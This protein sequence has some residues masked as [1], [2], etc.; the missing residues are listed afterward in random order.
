MSLEQGKCSPR[1]HQ[2]LSYSQATGAGH[3][4]SVPHSGSQQQS[5]QHR[6]A[7]LLLLYAD[8]KPGYQSS[9]TNKLAKYSSQIIPAHSSTTALTQPH[10]QLSVQM[11]PSLLPHAQQPLSHPASVPVTEHHVEQ[12]E[13]RPESSPAGIMNPPYVFQRPGDLQQSFQPQVQSSLQQRILPMI[14]P[15]ST[16]CQ[17]VPSHPPVNAHSI[18]TVPSNTVNPNYVQSQF[19]QSLP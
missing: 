18:T 7:S 17:T 11:P 15:M 2:G 6:S 1:M 9:E 4:K 19:V 3:Q 14:S 12:R 10:S 5:I 16:V 13:P 8:T